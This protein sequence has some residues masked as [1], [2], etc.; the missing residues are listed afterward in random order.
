MGNIAKQNQNQK[1]KQDRN[2]IK[3]RHAVITVGLLVI[4]IWISIAI[5]MYVN[6]LELTQ[7]GN[8]SSSQMMGYVL[9]TSDGKTIVIDGGTVQDADNLK[10]QILQYGDKVDAWFLTHP[11]KDHVGA[12]IT[13]MTEQ[14]PI[15]VKK[16]YVTLNDL[17]WY[18][19]NEP[20]RKE[21]IENFFK[22]IEQ[23]VIKEKIEEVTL[24]QIIHIGNLKCEILG[25]KNPE[26][27]H[28]AINNSSMVIKMYI[29]QKTILF[30]GDT[31][32][33][34]S[35]KLLQKQSKEK[36]TADVVQMAHHGQ[37]GAIEELY[38]VIKPK[39][40]LWPTPDWL[41]ENNIGTGKNSGPWKTLETR[42]WMEKLAVRQQMIEK[43]GNQ[44]ITIY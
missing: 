22:I 20:N 28:N 15:E 27:T 40:C 29:N 30:L 23:E 18:Q 2:P 13:M 11:H 8:Q 9:R 31:G 7:L 21:E 34:S 32:I 38:Q 3:V 43:D 4:F 1:Q 39:I 26:I 41:W 44:T 25:I 14:T 24:G 19:T 42:A 35:Q 17:E 16:I 33:E 12:F 5:G 10:A 37:S 6:R 36:L